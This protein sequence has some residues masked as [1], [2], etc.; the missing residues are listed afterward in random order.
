MF[1]Y[2]ISKRKLHVSIGVNR[3]R[4]NETFKVTALIKSL[5][6]D[7]VIQ[8]DSAAGPASKKSNLI[9]ILRQGERTGERERDKAIVN[10]K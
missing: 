9:T 7:L 8:I 5:F 6:S 10:A 4:N 3:R 1:V 2:H